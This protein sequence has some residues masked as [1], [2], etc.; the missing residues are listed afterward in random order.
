MQ[1]QETWAVGKRQVENLLLSAQSDTEA[2][3]GRLG[4]ARELSQQAVESALRNDQQETAGEWQMNAALREAEFGN[5][6]RAIQQV[7]MVLAKSPNREVQILG[8][9]A[10]ARAGDSKR[11][12]QMADDLAKRFP[13]DTAINRYWLPSIRAAIEINRKRPAKALEILATSVPYELGNPLPQGE[14]GAY[15]YPVY[16]RGQSYLLLQKS[17]EAAAEFQKV[18]GHPG[19]TVNC[20]LGALAHLQLG[21]AYTLAGNSAKARTA[22]KDFLALWK[23]ADPGVPRL[24]QARSEYARLQ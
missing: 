22:Y 1:Q 23:D 21:R 19:V 16:V 10:L 4:R 12:E 9:L 17:E 20:P 18:L 2:F 14:I 5:E 7:D 8:A 15:L 6:P 11:A 3:F 24:M 13:S